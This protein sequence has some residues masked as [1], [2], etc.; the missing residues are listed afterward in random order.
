MA[1]S[2]QLQ[3]PLSLFSGVRKNIYIIHLFV[4]VTSIE[5]AS[6]LLSYQYR[7]DCFWSSTMFTLW[8]LNRLAFNVLLTWHRY[9]PWKRVTAADLHGVCMSKDMLHESFVTHLLSLRFRCGVY[10]ELFYSSMSSSHYCILRNQ[11]KHQIN[12][13]F[14]VMHLSVL[15]ST[16]IDIV[17]CDKSAAQNK[18]LQK[19]NKNFKN[20][21]IPKL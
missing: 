4:F 17:A 19:G 7:T 20:V 16:E 1:F 15:L 5:L 6:N 9:K 11:Y 10:N 21:S 3:S 14:L 12:I 2:W 13:I 18:I 8:T